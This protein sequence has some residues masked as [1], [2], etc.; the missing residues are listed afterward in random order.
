MIDLFWICVCLII[1]LLL[2]REGA[3]ELEAADGQICT[4]AIDSSDAVTEGVERCLF[5]GFSAAEAL[6]AAFRFG[7]LEGSTISMDDDGISIGTAK[8]LVTFCGG[9]G[10][11]V[12]TV[13]FGFVGISTR[14]ARVTFE[15]IEETALISSAIFRCL[16][17]LPPSNFFWTRFHDD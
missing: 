12:I 3:L 8:S 16:L 11:A 5:D 1:C 9:F 13:R 6:V 7:L 2:F 15:C 14:R 4:D 10:G 17:R